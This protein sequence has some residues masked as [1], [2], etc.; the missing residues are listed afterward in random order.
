MDKT[1]RPFLASCLLVSLVM[2]CKPR[3]DDGST[4]RDDAGAAA[5]AEAANPAWTP[6]SVIRDDS[7]FFDDATDP[8]NGMPDVGGWWVT[9]IHATLL[10]RTGEVLVTGWGRKDQHSCHVHGASDPDVQ[11]QIGSRRNGTTFLLDPFA[12]GTKDTITLK[13]EPGTGG[14]WLHEDF[15]TTQQVKD[16]MYCSGHA[17]TA[18]G[19][20]LYSGGAQY[21]SLG[22]TK[23]E[24]EFG[25][26]YLR[27]FD[28]ATRKMQ[29][30]KTQ[31]GKTARMTG[32]PKFPLSDYGPNVSEIFKGLRDGQ[33][34]VNTAWYPTNLRLPDGKMLIQAG[35]VNCCNKSNN[36][37]DYFANS[38]FHVYDG[39]NAGAPL[40]LLLA[41][42][43]R[44]D[45]ELLQPGQK[46]YV[47]MHLLHRPVKKQN[48]FYTVLMFGYRGRIVLFNPTTKKFW[49][50]AHGQRDGAAWDATSALLPDGKLMIFGGSENPAV[51]QRIDIYDVEADKWSK[52]DT[53][54]GRN[55]A[56]AV[57][58]PD[59]KVLITNGWTDNQN[60]KGTEDDRRKP[61]IFDPRTKTVETLAAWPDA[62]E[63][64]Y[65]SFA[66]LL[67]DASLLVGGGTF[68]PKET[69]AE[70]G[71]EQPTLRRFALPYLSKGPRPKWASTAPLTVKAGG[72][73]FT[74][75][76][77]D[78]APLDAGRGM[79]LLAPGAMTHAFDQNQRYVALKF[80]QQG[81]KVTV[82][83]PKD[84]QLAPPGEYL[85]Y[86]LSAEG[87]PSEGR[88]VT[89]PRP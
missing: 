46:D 43:E 8:V 77:G 51:S 17:P 12:V 63:R 33:G 41:H 29:R 5:E 9:P 53:G 75:D 3:R 87:V 68:S 20:I 1:F 40:K 16:V 4:L 54:V 21:Y 48:D 69:T 14:Q 32:G 62:R 28:P 89:V 44:A 50:P 45:Q 34:R 61:Q 26:D 83:A 6:V 65:H 35:F 22:K 84:T 18:E 7:K 71:C 30:V 23:F 31:D 82:E 74:V 11:E 55:N 58:L 2:G 59:G 57:L 27:R 39:K 79:A 80:Q 60:V 37:R 36:A 70:I 85:L 42:N 24:V 76:L 73:K 25:L 13:K 49:L 64:G 47:Q 78:A 88:L 67:K 15:L 81:T 66:L 52:V 86:A 72:P 19:S 56:V 10:P 38:A